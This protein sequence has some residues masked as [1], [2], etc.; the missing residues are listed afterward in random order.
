MFLIASTGRAGTMGLC[1]GLNRFSDH[2]VEHEPPPE[3]L[4]EGYRKHNGRR[5]RSLTFRRRMRFFAA[6]DGTPYGQSFRSAPLVHDVAQVAPTARFLVLLRD[7][8][9]YLRSAHSRGVLS[10]GGRWDATR[11]MPPG[12]E[13]RAL[14]D[15]LGL[16]WLE[17]NRY[18]I[19]FHRSTDR[20]VLHVMRD[21]RPEVAGIAASLGVTITDP[22]GLDD[23]LSGTPNA[24]GVGPERSPL[25]LSTMSP[26]VRGRLD[27]MWGAAVELARGR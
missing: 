4:E 23:F 11:I 19:D 27:D 21:L 24:G 25:D 6:R 5:Y 13:G 2:Q 10:K 3:L 15:Q 16:H 1:E 18:L 14:V 20:S 9:D 17:V 12:T 26:D 22:A 8:D 7:P